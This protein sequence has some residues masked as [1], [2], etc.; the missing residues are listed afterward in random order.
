M[1]LEV[2]TISHGH[3]ESGFFSA[4]TGF[5][6]LGE[7]SFATRHLCEFAQYIAEHSRF[8]QTRVLSYDLDKYWERCNG[9][10]SEICQLVCNLGSHF[11]LNSQNM[12]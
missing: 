10:L 5:V 2:E 8:E 7:Y 6:R 4:F 1:T 9:G 12:N 11:Y 3:I